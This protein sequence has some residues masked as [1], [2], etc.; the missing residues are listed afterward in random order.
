MYQFE[1]FFVKMQVLI[2]LI[3]SNLSIFCRFSCRKT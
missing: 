3:V 1:D 2:R